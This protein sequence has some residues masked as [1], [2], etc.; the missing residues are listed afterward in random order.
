MRFQAAE[1][2]RRIA[3]PLAC[4]ILCAAGAALAAERG[5]PEDTTL[6]LEAKPMKGSKRVPILQIESKGEA[7]IGLWCNRVPAQLV[8]AGDTVTILLG[9]PTAQRCDAE[10]MDADE[11]L[12]A[13][14]QAVSTWSRQGDLLT[15]EGERTLRFRIATN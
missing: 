10:R 9:T 8:V 7:S 15:L 4:L 2:A 14:L 6:L 3:G 12:L 1:W 5:F 11:E 13:A